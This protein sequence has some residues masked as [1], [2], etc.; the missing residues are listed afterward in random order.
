FRELGYLTANVREFPGGF[1]GTGK[2]DWNFNMPG[3]PFDS[4]RWGDLKTN[5][6][7]FA[8]INF[9]ETN[10]KFHAPKRADPAKVELPPYYPDHPVAR[11]DC[12]AYLDDLTNL[13][14]KIGQLLAQLERDGLADNTIIFFFG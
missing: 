8:Q 5:Q 2:T 7:I 11:A 9:Q 13:D 14:Q 10:R 6:P 1:R 12:A 3:T 4:D